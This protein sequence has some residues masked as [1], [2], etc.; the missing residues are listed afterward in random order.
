MAFQYGDTCVSL[1]STSFENLLP[2]SFPAF[3]EKTLE[4]ATCKLSAD[5]IRPLHSMLSALGSSYFEYLPQE[6]LG[7]LQDRMQALLRSLPVDENVTSLLCLSVLA[8]ITARKSSSERR[9]SDFSGPAHQ[10]GQPFF[11][12]KHAQKTLDLIVLKSISICSANYKLA[13]ERSLEGL[14]LTEEIAYAVELAERHTWLAKNRGKMR[15]LSEKIL[16]SDIDQELQCAAINFVAALVGDLPMPDDLRSTLESQMLTPELLVLSPVALSKGIRSINSNILTTQLAAA[17]RIVCTNRYSSDASLIA[18][19]NARYLVAALIENIEA[20]PSLRIAILDCVS[21][22]D[23]LLQLNQLVLAKPSD[24]RASSKHNVQDTCPSTIYEAQ[25]L[26]YDKISVLLLKCGLLSAQPPNSK[27]QAM[28]FRLLDSERGATVPEARCTAFTKLPSETKSRISLFEADSVPE[29]RSIS[30]GWRETLLNQ[31]SRDASSRYDSI[32]RVVSGVC[33]DLELRCNEVERPLREE[34]A[35]TSNLE[36]RNDDAQA[37]IRKLREE[38]QSHDSTHENW[39]AET[40]QLRKQ[41]SISEGRLKSL[42]ADLESTKQ[43]FEQAKTE[44]HRVADAAAESS[45]ERDLAYMATLKAKDELFEQQVLEFNTARTRIKMLEEEVQQAKVRDAE[46]MQKI[47]QMQLAVAHLE[48]RI[49]EQET[50][51]KS[52]RSEIDLL[53]QTKQRLTEEKDEA[54]AIAKEAADEQILTIADLTKQLDERRSE[55]NALQAKFD[56]V[57]K[58]ME[59]EHKNH[60]TSHDAAIQE[61]Q[62]QLIEAEEK[63]GKTRKDCDSIVQELQKT[64]A[65]LRQDRERREKE[66]AEA[67]ELSRRLMTVVGIQDPITSTA[68]KVLKHDRNHQHLQ[69]DS[70]SPDK[71]F[72]GVSAES[73]TQGSESSSQSHGPTPKRNKI[74]QCP[75]PR[76][77]RVSIDGLKPKTPARTSFQPGRRHRQ[78]LS[79]ALTVQ[80]RWFTTPTLPQNRKEDLAS[81]DPSPGILEVSNEVQYRSSDEFFDGDDIFASTDQRQLSALKNTLRPTYD[82]ETTTEL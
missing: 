9:H 26:L 6:L 51:I 36:N 57:V 71:A 23:L 15:K 73:A 7:R 58:S 62:K 66:F 45:R 64:N 39:K 4:R 70:Q 60:K 30:H 3:L 19:E 76:R 50:V 17:I 78:P 1:L 41:L 35:R 27:L 69:N 12:G 14:L 67:H 31:M 25:G 68:K 21:D 44:A 33:R 10:Q 80:N 37:W 49:D 46:R 13:K 79:D 8:R 42:L 29:T 20:V 61:L 32:V 22:E 81:I 43:E 16:R 53:H 40:N 18:I 77:R 5:S 72:R 34:Q 59:A 2:S 56:D 82:D 38:A 24:I 65:R 55:T 52:N 75:L 54:T 11:T 63:T 48:R 28:F 47:Q 74:Q